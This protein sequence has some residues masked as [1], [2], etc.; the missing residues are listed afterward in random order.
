MSRILL[1][2]LVVFAACSEPERPEDF[3]VELWGSCMWEGQEVPDL[4]EVGLVCAGVCQQK[5]SGIDDKSCPSLD[6][7]VEG[8]FADRCSF[9]CDY[10]SARDSGKNPCP[11]TG[12][13]TLICSRFG[14]CVGGL[15]GG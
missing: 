2:A 13:G 4:C 9:P 14:Y 15:G 1:A 12:G 7:M 8:C 10:A 11:D 6:G 3:S 5:C